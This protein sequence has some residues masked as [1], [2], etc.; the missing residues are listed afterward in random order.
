MFPVQD[1]TYVIAPNWTYRPGGAIALG[2][3]I[4]DPFRPQHVLSKPT[5]PLPE[6]ETALEHDWTLATE[7]LRSVNVGI[8]TRMFDQLSVKLGPRRN[9]GRKVDIFM[10][11]L[12]TVYFKEQP[13]MEEIQERVNEERVRSILSP[14][15]IFRYPVYMVTGI[16][17]AKGFTMVHEGTEHY[18]F[19]LS[20]ADTVAPQLGV[21][22]SAGVSSKKTRTDGFWSSNEII[23]AYQLLIIKPKGWGQKLAYEL[24]DFRHKAALLVDDDDDDDGDEEA[25]GDVE[26]EVVTGTDENIAEV[27]KGIVPLN[28]DNKQHAW[29]FQAV[30]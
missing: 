27:Q 23:F 22:A 28:P 5:K 14:G 24:D 30:R 3:I 18:L 2:N 29:V 21:G 8:W 6:T 12:E 11:A 10:K 16:K 1:P 26:I 7:K 15:S 19:S 9:R 25:E 4:L 17:I 20:L 13:S